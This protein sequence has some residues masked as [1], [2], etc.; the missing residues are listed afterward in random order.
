ML[1]AAGLLGIFVA[2]GHGVVAEWHVF[3]EARVEP[4]K[5]RDLLRIIWQ[6]STVDWIV[7]GVL[8]IAAPALG[9]QA[10]RQWIIAAAV[11]VYG[12]AAV[13]NAVATQGQHIGWLLAAGVVGLALL[14]L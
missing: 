4:Q 13:G 12:Y 7:I 9:S 14:G 11:V 5:M 8:L 10:A 1:R 6:A 3:A 2:I